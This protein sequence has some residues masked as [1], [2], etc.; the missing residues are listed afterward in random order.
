MILKLKRTPGLYLAGFMGCGKTTV[1]HR[2]A[3]E[4]GWHF[5]DI[6]EDI[7]SEQQVSIAQIF[8]IRGEQAFREIETAAIR[9]R[10]KSVERGRPTVVAIGGGAFITEEN[11]SLLEEHG[12]T[13]WLDCPLEI[14]RQRLAGCDNR[15][16]ARDDDR[17]A[18]LYQQRQ[19]AYA[20]ADYRIEADKDVEE[21]VHAILHLPI[22]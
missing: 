10:V 5:A 18:K 7:E 22:F 13:I 6:D 21:V 11:Y 16:L 4:L 12:I 20:K 19:A 17:L 2:V 1:A 15:P 14:I 9:S 8:D 3:D